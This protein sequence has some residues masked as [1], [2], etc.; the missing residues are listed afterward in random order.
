MPAVPGG[1]PRAGR[2]RPPAPYVGRP[3]QPTR[4]VPRA[5]VSGSPVHARIGGESPVPE[6]RATGASPAGEAGKIHPLTI[7]PPIA[8]RPPADILRQ[9]PDPFPRRTQRYARLDGLTDSPDTPW[10]QP[11]ANPGYVPSALLVSAAL[12]LPV[13]D[14]ALREI[15]YLPSVIQEGIV[16]TIASFGDRVDDNDVARATSGWLTAAQNPGGG[17]R[18]SAAAN[19]AEN[20]PT[21]DTLE[22]FRQEVRDLRE[23]AAEMTPLRQQQLLRLIEAV[24]RQDLRAAQQAWNEFQSDNTTTAPPRTSPDQPDLAPDFLPS[25]EAEPFDYGQ[26]EASPYAP[27]RTI[28]GVQRLGAAQ[29]GRIPPLEEEIGFSLGLAGAEEPVDLNAP[30]TNPYEE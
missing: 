10:R 14:S 4:A 22:D 27:P 19:A 5:A 30:P 8:G 16:P 3:Q 25:F 17:A 6:I 11:P 7:H 26:I 9:N 21:P 29:A 28:A 23:E 18:Q 15:A 24:D 13:S 20:Q 2:P 1:R 12:G